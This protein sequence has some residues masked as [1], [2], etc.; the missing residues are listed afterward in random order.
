M[1]RKLKTD[2]PGRPNDPPAAVC[3]LVPTKQGS[4]PGGIACQVPSPHHALATILTR[5]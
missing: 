3:P 2:T 1:G 4:R 5:A